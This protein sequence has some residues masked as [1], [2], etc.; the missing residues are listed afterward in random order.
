MCWWC[1]ERPADSREHKFKRSDLVREHG[2]GE[3]RGERTLVVYGK[4]QREARSTKND[5]LKFAPSLCAK[6]NNERSQPF[7]KAYDR[8][9][10]ELFKREDEVLAARSFDLRAAFGSEWSSLGEDVLR[11]FVKHIGCRISE[12]LTVSG[13]RTVPADAL[14]FLDGGPA[15]T[16]LSC[17]MW[18]E[19]TWLRFC[20][21]GAEDPLWI[22]PMGIEAV[23]P[24]PNGRLGSRWTYGWL[25]FGWEFWGEDEG[26]HPFETPE[27]E[28]PIVAARPVDLEFGLVPT[29][30]N[31]ELEEL[32]QQW[33]N[34]VTGG[35]PVAPDGVLGRSPVGQKFLGAALDFEA[36]LRDRAPDRRELF[37]EDPVPAAEIEVIRVG[38]LCGIA[39]TVWARCSLDL[40]EIRSIELTERLIEPESI[41]AAIAEM[42]E[43]TPEEGWLTVCNNFAA[44]SSLK[45]IEAHE[46]GVDAEEGEEALLVAASLAGAC[47]AAAGAASEDWPAAWDAI[48]AAAA[49]I[50]RVEQVFESP[51]LPA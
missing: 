1:R 39:R 14:D 25:V 34:K 40:Q 11:Y 44:M 16:N 6:C 20:E 24:G 10:E 22:K 17:E 31:R 3:L 32:D 36:G 19:P 21:M 29:T 8:F 12:S 27:L 49:I 18:I 13:E 42:P 45:M 9:I 7:D 15:P 46:H 38:L 30:A 43:R 47:G 4:Q 37:V 2:R 48:S 26:S 33:L 50:A 51:S 23:H 35:E 28:L 41:G 5:A